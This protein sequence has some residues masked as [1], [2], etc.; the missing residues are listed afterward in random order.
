LRQFVFAI[1]AIYVYIEDE[2]HF[3]VNCSAHSDVVKLVTL[4]FLLLY[5]DK[6]R[7]GGGKKS[8]GASIVLKHFNMEVQF[9]GTKN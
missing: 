5:N 1:L 8:V 4:S 7:E 9:Y 3:A 6:T 2:Y